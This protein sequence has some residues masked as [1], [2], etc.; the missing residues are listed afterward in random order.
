MGSEV[1]AGIADKNRIPKMRRDL[2]VIR[3]DTEI[4][5]RSVKSNFSRYCFPPYFHEKNNQRRFRMKCFRKICRP[6]AIIAAASLFAVSIPVPAAHAALVGTEHV[7]TV[8]Q[9]KLR[10]KLNAFLSRE[11]VQTQMRALGVSPAEAQARVAS[12]S[13]EEVAQAQGKLD[14][15]PSGQSFVGA[16]IGAGLL[17]FIVLLITD[18]LGLTHVFGFTNKGSVKAGN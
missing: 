1:Q 3:C 14:S 11:D 18:I 4:H 5:R 15:M 9:G 2:H 7:V 13:D 6:I 10:A 8:E 12:M 16:L 17:I